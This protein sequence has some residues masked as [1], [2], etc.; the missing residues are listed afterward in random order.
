MVCL[1]SSYCN[2]FFLGKM[3][4][5]EEGVSNDVFKEKEEAP[6]EPAEIQ[7]EDDQILKEEEAKK[8]EL[9]SVYIKEVVREERMKFF[10]VP[11]YN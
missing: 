10:L 7:E 2:M 9:N 1:R 6:E 4:K 5:I 3:L 11:R 8:E